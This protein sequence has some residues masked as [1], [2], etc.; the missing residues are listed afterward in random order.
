MPDIERIVAAWCE[1]DRAHAML[2]ADRA[3][4]ETTR[5]ARV[6]VVERVLAGEQRDL[7]NACA[8]LGRLIATEHGSPTFA[9]ATID[10]AHAALGG[11]AAEWVAPARAAVA[12]GFVAALAERA[13]ADSR[14]RW[15]YPRCVVRIDAATVAVAAGY[16]EEDGEA[17][18]AWAERVA[19]ECSRSGVKR[20]T[21]S[22]TEQATAALAEAFALVG[23]EQ[24]AASEHRTRRLR[25]SWPP[26][27]S[28]GRQ[29]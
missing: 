22:G 23:I 19:R 29:C 12:E 28:R 17:L 15:E 26:W 20:A 21:V 10:G 9:V 24:S 16:P 18:A 5:A 13:Q 11:G 7:Y 27:R 3:L 25:L 14:A 4:I 2:P 6:L 8:V 1:H